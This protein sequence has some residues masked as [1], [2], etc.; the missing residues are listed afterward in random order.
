MGSFRTFLTQKN[1]RIRLEY[2]RVSLLSAV[3]LV[4]FFDI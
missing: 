4:E 2:S 1:L 3:A